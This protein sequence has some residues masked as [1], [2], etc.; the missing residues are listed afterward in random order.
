MNDEY[1]TLFNET[2]KGIN[3]VKHLNAENFFKSKMKNFQIAFMN[4]L[5]K[6]NLIRNLGNFL[7]KAM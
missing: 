3:E 1:L 2:I 4:A 7:K 5:I 6:L